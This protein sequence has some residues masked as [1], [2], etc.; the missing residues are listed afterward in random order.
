MEDGKSS[1]VLRVT[2]ETPCLNLVQEQ[3][4][5]D[6]DLND[7]IN[8]LCDKILPDDKQAARNVHEEICTS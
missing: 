8:Y 7:L 6:R 3:Q 1:T 2:E 4:R 5:Q